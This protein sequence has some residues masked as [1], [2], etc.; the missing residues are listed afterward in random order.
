[1]IGQWEGRH[2][3]SAFC[4]RS[5]VWR[6]TGALKRDPQ[7][8][9]WGYRLARDGGTGLLSTPR[10]PSTP[11]LLSLEE[12]KA[13]LTRSGKQSGGC[14]AGS[15]L[16]PPVLS[17]SLK[18][19]HRRRHK[20]YRPR[21]KVLDT[22]PAPRRRVPRGRQP[23]IRAALCASTHAAPGIVFAK[24]TEGQGH[25]RLPAHPERG[26]QTSAWD[27]PKRRVEV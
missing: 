16:H 23:V 14:D 8:R 27:C 9:L 22:A 11:I 6:R 25:E 18:R 3:V 24:A 7:P 4:P 12:E 2:R 15:P 19:R 17:A 26:E 13:L 1:M 5:S 10:T 20:N 21:L